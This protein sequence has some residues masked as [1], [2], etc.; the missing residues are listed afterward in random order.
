[1]AVEPLE[2]NCSLFYNSKIQGW[3]QDLVK[4]GPQIFLTDFCQLCAVLIGWGP[5]PALGPLEA[6]GFFITKYAFS[7]FLGT[8]LYH[9]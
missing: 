8:F 2:E 4:G 1:M 3:I 5:G 6:L 9:F 7:P